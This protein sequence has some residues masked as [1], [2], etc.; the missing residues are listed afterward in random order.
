LIGTGALAINHSVI[1]KDWNPRSLKCTDSAQ[2]LPLEQF[3][4][5]FPCHQ[6]DYFDLTPI[7]GGRKT[8][9]RRRFFQRQL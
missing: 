7:S 4:K 2:V 8:H 9:F 1:G 3:L 5:L 6:C